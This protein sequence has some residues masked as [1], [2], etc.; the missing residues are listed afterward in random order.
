MDESGAEHSGVDGAGGHSNARGGLR[1]L[2]RGVA[3]EGEP[4][5][6]P[7]RMV[8]GAPEDVQEPRSGPGA[9]LTVGVSVPLPAELAGWSEFRAPHQ[10]SPAVWTHPA[11]VRASED[12]R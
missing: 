7:N 1:A 9:P 3:T 6:A 10:P 2:E 12:S 4:S 8:A 5:G 11:G